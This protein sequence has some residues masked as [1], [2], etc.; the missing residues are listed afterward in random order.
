MNLAWAAAGAVAGVPIGTLLRGPVFRMAVPSGEPERTSC[1]H[2]SAAVR[3][4]GAVSC[5]KCGRR[6]GPPAALELVTAAVLA[7]LCARFAGQSAVLAFGF[8]GTLGVALGA[9]DIAVYRLPN[10]LTLPAYPATLALLSPAAVLGHDAGALLRALLASV[11]LA[12]TYLLLALL[13]PGQLGAG[14]VKLAGLIGLACR[15]LRSG[16]R[17]RAFRHRQ[18]RTAGDAP[19]HPAQ[20]YLLRAVHAGRRAARHSRQRDI[21]LPR[22]RECAGGVNTIYLRCDSAGFKDD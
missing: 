2:C 6:L 21:A 9:I 5:R 18:P 1:P 10:R 15:D 4:W 22:T 3:R 19:D 14:D 13:R 8:L 16:A 17:L 7:L 12:V 11:A 20:R